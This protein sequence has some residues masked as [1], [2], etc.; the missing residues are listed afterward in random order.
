MHKKLGIIVPYRN[1]FDQLQEFKR[2]IK[3]YL[4]KK[5]IPFEI[6]VIQ[7]DDAKLFNRGVLL[8]IG[9]TYAKKDNC[10]Y[11]VFHDVD[12]IPFRVDYSY[13]EIP[14]HLATRFKN[15]DRFMFD[16]YFGGVTLFPMDIFEKIN[17]Y[18]NKYWGWG[19]EDNDLLY[20]CIKNGVELDTLKIKNQ[21]HSKQKLKFN[22]NNASVKSLNPIDFK[23]PT[24]IFISF[25]PDELTCDVNQY[26]DDFNVF[27][28]PGYD[29]S[30]SYNSYSRYNICLF[31]KN[32]EALF[33]NSKIIKDYYTNLIITIDEKNQE[34]KVYQD[35]EILETIK[36]FGELYDYTTQEY[37]Y[38]G[39]GNPLSDS[40]FKYFNG[41]FDKL[42]IFEGI[43]NEDDINRLIKN[44]FNVDHNKILWYDADVIENY[45]LKDLS[46]HGNHGEIINCEIVE[47][48]IEKYKEV[49]IP[50]RRDSIFRCLPHEENG[51]VNNAW[52]DQSIR[53]NQIRFYNEVC[54]NDDLLYNEG[55]STLEFAEHEILT[56]EENVKHITVGV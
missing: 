35:G 26:S 8:N 46:D 27:T 9:Y 20:R 48:E 6:Y 21:E 16:E 14:I 4:S 42:V 31:N 17:G 19:Y 39:M 34:I 32:N 24:S 47:D 36:D 30:I 5:K 37:L 15:V 55:L 53:W 25:K 38:L 43:L 45:K 28:I 44:E 2:E 10:D 41:L 13:N 1:R 54:K 50:Y 3:K 7:Q 12:M 33:I 56:D 49:K 11:V 52:K 23:T 51:F 29:F 18:S 40:G 22:G